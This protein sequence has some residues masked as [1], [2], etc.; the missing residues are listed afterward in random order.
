MTFETVKC[1]Q[2]RGTHNRLQPQAM[3]V[4][5]TIKIC[6]YL[7]HRLR[8][9]NPRA[10]EKVPAAMSGRWPNL[11]NSAPVKQ[12]R[13]KVTKAWTLRT[14]SRLSKAS[15]RGLRG[16]P[17]DLAAVEISDCCTPSS[18]RRERRT[19]CIV[20]T[21]PCTAFESHLSPRIAQSR[22]R[23]SKRRLGRV[24]RSRKGHANECR[25]TGDDQP[26]LLSSAFP[27]V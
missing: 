21:L 9:Q 14:I 15:R 25:L 13:P 27:Q 17:G 5:W 3:S 6:Q 16:N 20:E 7:V 4:A 19:L 22:R 18:S 8:I 10:K 12:A 11:S 24:R 2:Y 23:Q 1:V 26:R